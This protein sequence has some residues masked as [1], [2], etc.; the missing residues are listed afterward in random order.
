MIFEWQKLRKILKT[1]Y[2]KNLKI[3]QPKIQKNTDILIEK[4]T[5][6]WK[7]ISKKYQNLKIPK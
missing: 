5:F 1:K 2:Q 4:K 6:N 7:N 3:Q